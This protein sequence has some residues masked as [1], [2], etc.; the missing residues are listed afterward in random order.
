MA[1]NHARLAL[2]PKP[3]VDIYGGNDIN[4]LAVPDLGYRM[5]L[6]N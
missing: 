4:E 1:I 5:T 2:T 3:D 6:I